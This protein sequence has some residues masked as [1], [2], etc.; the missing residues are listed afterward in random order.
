MIS[1]IF[2]TKFE[3]VLNQEHIALRNHLSLMAVGLH[4]PP[5][6]HL[7][8]AVYPAAVGLRDP[9]VADA[10]GLQGHDQTVAVGLPGPPAAVAVGLRPAVQPCLAELQVPHLE[11]LRAAVQPCLAEL[12]VPQEEPLRA[13]VQPCLAELQVPRE[14]PL[15][16]PATSIVAEE[17]SV[18]QEGTLPVQ[19]SLQVGL[20]GLLGVPALAHRDVAPVVGG[21]ALHHPLAVVT[22]VNSSL[23]GNES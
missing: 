16:V 8:D 20:T 22:C 6:V 4:G 23:V 11:H 5:V 14:E 15:P 21:G 7:Q 19:H 18:R 13:V 10:A 9:P 1:N 17:F 3:V 12:Q 2:Q